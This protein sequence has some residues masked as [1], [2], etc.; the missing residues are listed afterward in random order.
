[1]KSTPFIFDKAAIGLSL[2]CAVHCLLLPVTLIMLP[3][4][5]ATTF[6]GEEFHQ[7]MLV[8]VLPISLLAL[9]LGCRKHREMSI[10]LLGLMGLIIILVAA[11]FGHDLFGE[12]GEKVATLLGASLIALSH[13]RNQSLCHQHN[14]DH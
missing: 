8:A 4:L 5:A 10:M 14:C 6:G 3:S 2:F 1:V 11:L 13:V 7:W 9:T 12:I